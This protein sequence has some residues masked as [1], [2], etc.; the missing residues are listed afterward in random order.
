MLR[1]WI[2][3]SSGHRK[4][5][6]KALE[7]IYIDEILQHRDAIIVG[8]GRGTTLEDFLHSEDTDG[9][10]GIGAGNRWARNLNHGYNPFASQPGSRSWPT[11]PRRSDCWTFNWNVMTAKDWA[12]APNTI[13]YFNWN[14]GIA[15]YKAGNKEQ[16]YHILGHIMHLVEDMSVP[17]HVYIIDHG[18]ELASLIPDIPDCIINFYP[19]YLIEDA[20]E[21]YLSKDFDNFLCCKSETPR[22]N[23]A[24][25]YIERLAKLTHGL[26]CISVNGETKCNFFSMMVKT[27][28][29]VKWMVTEVT[30]QEED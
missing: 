12:K 19:G 4:I 22:F 14:N 18:K 27:T 15:Q 23:T 3:S 6:D 26:R 29:M 5:T 25:E 1:D 21:D 13:N 11:P 10:P 7:F 30:M 24:E 20:L 28:Q 8:S 17:A 2:K 16:A 9:V